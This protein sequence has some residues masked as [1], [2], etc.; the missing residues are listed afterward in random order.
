M[1]V[2]GGQRAVTTSKVPCNMNALAPYHRLD[3]LN[4]SAG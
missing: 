3:G 1:Y 2:P 4:A